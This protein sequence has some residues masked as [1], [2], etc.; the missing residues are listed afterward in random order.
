MG[1]T[2][3][4][5]IR[6]LGGVLGKIGKININKFRDRLKLQKW[7][8]LL[9]AFGLYMDYNFSWYMYGPYSPE[10]ARD[11]FALKDLGISPT[12]E[13]PIEE[14]KKFV[15]FLD[16]LG[17]KI[18]DAEWLELVASMHFLS[19]LYPNATKTVIFDKLK[20]K[21]TFFTTKK[22]EQAWN[23]CKTYDMV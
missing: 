21:R 14:K 19:K 20:A 4:Y 3:S 16:F 23:I 17:S 8:Y 10:L 6:V 11:G 13:I 12:Y 5:K 7:I 15:R 2:E 1:Y 9:Q 18:N 22:C